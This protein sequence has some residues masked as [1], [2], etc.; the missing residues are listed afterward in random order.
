MSLQGLLPAVMQQLQDDDC[1]VMKAALTVLSNIL[2]VV[3]RQ[4]AGPIALQLLN[5]LLPLFENVRQRESPLGGMCV[6][7]RDGA[8][9]SMCAHWP[10]SG[11]SSHFSG[12]EKRGLRSSPLTSLVLGEQLRAKAVHPPQQRC[13]EGFIQVSQKADEEGCAQKPPA[14]VLPPA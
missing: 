13:D 3:D 4:T 10:V 5:M 9:L 6:W 1:D 8:S 12:L 2:C 14:L 7:L 11:G